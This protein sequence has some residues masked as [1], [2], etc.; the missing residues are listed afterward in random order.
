MM[1]AK[2]HHP[3]KKKKIKE[4]TAK[5]IAVFFFTSIESL[6]QNPHHKSLETLS[7]KLI[8]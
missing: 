4:L 5:V 2:P 8:E 6:L 1:F 7:V 3:G